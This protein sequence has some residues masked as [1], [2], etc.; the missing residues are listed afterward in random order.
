[1]PHVVNG[2]DSN[3]KGLGIKTFS[4]QV[5]KSGTI[6]LKQ[7]GLRFKAGANVGL[8]KDWTLFA[9]CD[10]KVA[11]DPRKIVSVTQNPK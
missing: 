5:V 7:K 8:G 1:M 10:G 4:G 3:P 11:F 6:I 2:R 9:L